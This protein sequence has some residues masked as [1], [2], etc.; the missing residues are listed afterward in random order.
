MTKTATV[1]LQQTIYDIAVQHCG[2]MEAVFD[3]CRLNDIGFTD[4]LVHGQVLKLPNPRDKAVVRYFLDG[5]YVP[6]TDFNLSIQE[7]IE[8][9]GIEYDFIVS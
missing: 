8:Y 2:T 3:L 4:V 6:A 9:W 7:G 1:Q 5:K